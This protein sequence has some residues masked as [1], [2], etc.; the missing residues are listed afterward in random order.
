MRNEPDVDADREHDRRL[1]AQIDP[2]IGQLS[3]LGKFELA[4][5]L[6]GESMF[7]SVR[8]RREPAPIDTRIVHVIGPAKVEA[9]DGVGGSEDRSASPAADDGTRD[10]VHPSTSQE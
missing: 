4:T 3:P 5:R 1:R 2:L 10:S 8:R 7:D 9:G 6:I